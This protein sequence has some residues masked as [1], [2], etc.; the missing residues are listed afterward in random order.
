[1][2][3]LYGK[4]TFLYSC[5]MSIFN[6]EDYLKVGFPDQNLQQI[7]HLELQVQPKVDVEHILPVSIAATIQYFVNRGC[8]LQ[9]FEL[10]LYE[11]SDDLGGDNDDKHFLLR[12]A[13]FSSE[14]RAALVGLKVSK[15][16]TISVS[17]SQQRTIVE[18]ETEG[19]IGDFFCK[20]IRSLASQNN[21]T[22]TEEMVF[23]TEFLGGDE[24]HE[25]REDDSSEDSGE[26]F[27]ED[28]PDS[29]RTS[30]DISWCLRPQ[31][32]TAQTDSGSA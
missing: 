16:L 13:A 19:T 6:D 17:Y 23:D 10:L 28:D 5:D 18:H 9:T 30:Y 22:F 12:A 20:W 7:K 21:F 26:F 15:T 4:N 24:D 29:Y 32:S 1:M 25:A 31:Q 8:D 3:V 2:P 14:I 11:Q 27:D